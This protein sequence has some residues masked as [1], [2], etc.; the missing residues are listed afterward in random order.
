MSKS[1]IQDAFRK[2][3]GEPSLTDRELL[4]LIK[5]NPWSKVIG[6]NQPPTPK[7]IQALTEAGF[8]RRNRVAQSEVARRSSRAWR[9]AWLR[10][11]NQ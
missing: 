8:R 5:E 1:E 4:R 6:L 11:A 9:C 7:Q 2:L 3:T 10:S